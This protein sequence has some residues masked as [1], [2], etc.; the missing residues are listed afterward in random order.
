MDHGLLAHSRSGS[1]RYNLGDGVMKTD[2]RRYDI[3][4]TV[5][6]KTL[7]LH[8]VGIHELKH[9]RAKAQRKELKLNLAKRTDR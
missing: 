9:I 2:A 8:G 4:V 3:T 1:N 5:E 6:G 7:Q